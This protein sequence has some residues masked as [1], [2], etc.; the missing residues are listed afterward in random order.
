[1]PSQERMNE[2][3]RF[4]W[5]NV[6]SET[7]KTHWQTEGVR[8]VYNWVDVRDLADAH[9]LAL[10]NEVAS[11]ERINICRESFVWQ[12]WST[13]GFLWGSHQWPLILD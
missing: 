3:L 9:V 8:M 12:D 1:M 13:S 11:G 4:F 7:A 2:S 5:D 6:I 10:E